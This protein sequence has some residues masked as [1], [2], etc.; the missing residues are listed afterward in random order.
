M[1]IVRRT[2]RP[3]PFRIGP[4][5]AT[6]AVVAIFALFGPSIGLGLGADAGSTARAQAPEPGGLLGALA[7]GP[8]GREAGHVGAARARYV[9]VDLD[10]LAGP[11]IAV[12]STASADFVRVDLFDGGQVNAF[13]TRIDFNADGSYVWNGEAAGPADGR[14]TVAV[15]GGVASGTIERGGIVHQLFHV[16]DGIHELVEIDP[17]RM[18]GS[19]EPLRPD[20]S[21]GGAVSST[22]DSE[23][24]DRDAAHERDASH[25]HG[26]GKGIGTGT[27]PDASIDGVDAV[28]ADSG[29]EI[30]VMVVYTPAARSAAG[31]TSAML[32]LIDVAV[33]ETNQAYVNS[34]IDTSLRLVH[35]AEIAYTESGSFSTDLDRL[36]DTNDGYMDAVHTWRNTHH[37]DVVSLITNSTSFCGIA[38]VMQ[39]L[40][41]GFAPWAFSVVARVCATGYYTLGHEIGHN[42]GS[43]HDRANSGGNQGVYPYGYGHRSPAGTF[44]TVMAY[45]CPSGCPRIQHFSNPDVSYSGEPTGIDHDSDPA[46][47]AE[48]ALSINNTA[49]TVANFRDAPPQPPDGPT[50]LTATA[51]GTTIDLAWTDNA[52]DENGFRIVRADGGVGNWTVIVSLPPNTVSYANTGLP[53]STTFDYRVYAYNDSGDSNYSNVASATTGAAGEPV[54]RVAESE[55]AV[56]GQVTGSYVDTHADDDDAESIKETMSGGPPDSRFSFLEHRWTIDVAAG[57]SVTLYLKAWKTA[58]SDGDSFLFSYSTGG[59]YIDMITVANTSPDG[60]ASFNMPD[61]LQGDITVRVIDTNREAGHRNLDTVY[62]EHLYVRSEV[63]G[64]GGGGSPPAA[65]SGLAATI[66]GPTSIDLGW[67]DNASDETGFEIERR[68]GGGSWGQIAT[69]GANA[70]SF[71]DSGLAPD[72]AYEYRVRATN[73]DGDSAWS[74]VAGATTAPA[75]PSGLAATPISSNRVDLQWTDNASTETGFKVERRVEGGSWNQIATPGANSTTYSDTGVAPDTTYDYRVLAYNSS[76]DSGWSNIASA[77]TPPA[78]PITL[79]A[80]PQWFKGVHA[81]QLNWDGADGSNV[82]IERDGVVVATTPNDG[83]HFDI[84]GGTG[85][86]SYDY[87]VCE[88]DST[89]ECSEVVVV[90]F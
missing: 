36:Q 29:D 69:P 60:Y 5:F 11:G 58:S 15:R 8:D 25:E 49:Y 41:N 42:Q 18:P 57:D 81:A 64:G 52:D 40:S 47:S 12:G 7:A 65:P 90:S 89:T 77:T 66:A 83:S 1:R 51:D 63:P 17:S 73:A 35:A 28:L 32:A 70:T 19:L 9:S 2:F 76:G 88:E 87:R 80:S 16:R 27:G 21:S 20:P 6:A 46:N 39:T 72:T 13:R 56:A 62:V 22:P 59:S 82:D 78:D 34:D 48:N 14:V 45:D 86:A 10:R 50:G 67:T 37:A 74:N 43:M 23:R 55:T 33:A 4:G 79:T 68:A 85:S 75:A 30:D 31:G 84:I 71:A 53:Y 61:S 26:A 54:D 3:T 38:Y 44:R 24:L